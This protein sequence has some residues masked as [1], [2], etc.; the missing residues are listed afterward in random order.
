MRLEDRV[1]IV[2]GGGSGIGKAIS[3]GLAKEGAHVVVAARRAEPLEETAQ[4]IR[5]MGRRAL[6]VPTDI[7]ETYQVEAMVEKTLQELGKIDILINNA[8]LH[9]PASFL[10]ITEDDWFQS[11]NV[12][13][14]GV[15]RCTKAVTR[16]M[17]PRRSGVIVNV[18]CPHMELGMPWVHLGTA[19]S[20]QI[21]WTTGLAGELSPFGI[22]VNGVCPGLVP[23]EGM[24][25]ATDPQA[26]KELCE[27]EGMLGRTCTAEDVA[28]AV[29]FIV[30]DEASYMTAQV[31]YIDGGLTSLAQWTR[32]PPVRV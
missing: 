3:L 17:I 26:F 23:T 32:R 24:L 19:K 18:L 28:S 8:A 5:A 6:A 29:N 14:H 9:I 2:T 11:M 21:R 4:E 25:A 31:L 13:I 20:F 12:M 10:D 15:F 1:A 7:T 30:S 27:V 16:H 22:R